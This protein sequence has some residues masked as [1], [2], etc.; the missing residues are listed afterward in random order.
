M[1]ST[2]Q[3]RDRSCIGKRSPLIIGPTA[4]LGNFGQQ[5]AQTIQFFTPG[6]QSVVQVQQTCGEQTALTCPQA[7]NGAIV[8]LDLGAKYKA[9]NKPL[10]QASA[11]LK[12]TVQ[13]LN[14]AGFIVVLVT[15][16]GPINDPKVIE[17]NTI[18]YQVAEAEK[19]PLF[20]LYKIGV[21]KPNLVQNGVLT[22]PGPGKRA[23]FVATAGA[24]N[25]LDQFG[26]NV[27][28]LNTL[29]LLDELEKIVGK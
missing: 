12:A 28:T 7:A 14:N 8:F 27:A 24:P 3:P 25:P 5:Y 16:P 23:E 4:V 22:D 20:N 17:Y 26:V 29:Q 6:L 9:E 2:L 11:E 19:A 21:D 18:I 13:N 1:S 15:I 10:D